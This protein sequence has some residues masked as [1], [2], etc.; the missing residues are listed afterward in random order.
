MY[1][2]P[3]NPA[4]RRAIYQARRAMAPPMHRAMNACALARSIGLMVI[5]V[6]AINGHATV[7]VADPDQPTLVV[8][9]RL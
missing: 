4:K 8:N 2:K 9:W 5:G 1:R 3:R 6:H 7:C